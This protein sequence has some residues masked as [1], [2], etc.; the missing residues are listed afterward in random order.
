MTDHAVI[1]EP[2]KPATLPSAP[3]FT[4]LLTPT[5]LPNIHQHLVAKL[6]Y[7]SCPIHFFFF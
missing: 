2:I 1:Y 5:T 6:S 4:H 7:L 3:A